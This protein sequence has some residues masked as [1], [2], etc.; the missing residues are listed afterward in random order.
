MV[1]VKTNILSSFEQSCQV[2]INKNSYF[3]T[4]IISF[5]PN[6]NTFVIAPHV[7]IMNTTNIKWSFHFL[8][9]GAMTVGICGWISSRFPAKYAPR[10]RLASTLEQSRAK[11]A[12]WVYVLI[13]SVDSLDYL[14]NVLS[15]SVSYNYV[16][17][18]IW[19][20]PRLW[21]VIFNQI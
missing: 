3:R 16:L 21:L 2:V 19:C 15:W 8:L 14:V 12:R 20:R 9:Q 18:P 5:Y 7:L 10:P 1:F 11:D 17:E 13:C 4:I 6:N